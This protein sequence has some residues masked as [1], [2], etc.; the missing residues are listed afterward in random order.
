MNPFV[1]VM[2]D[3]VPKNLKRNGNERSNMIIFRMMLRGWNP[4][5]RKWTTTCQN[6]RYL[7]MYIFSVKEV[8]TYAS[9]ASFHLSQVGE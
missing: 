9:S 8:Q 5:T 1:S 4:P 6:F 7:P 2:Q 3:N